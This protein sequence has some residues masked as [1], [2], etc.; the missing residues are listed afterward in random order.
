MLHVEVGSTDTVMYDVT[1]FSDG[2]SA[3]YV[4]IAVVCTSRQDGDAGE[5]MFGKGRRLRFDAHLCLPIPML[6]K[7]EIRSLTKY[8]CQLS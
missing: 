1:I 7:L 4:G 2:V 8:L 5:T 3:R 6:I